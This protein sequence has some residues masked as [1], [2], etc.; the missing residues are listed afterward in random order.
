MSEAEASIPLHIFQELRALKALPRKG[1]RFIQQA[2]LRKSRLTLKQQGTPK[3]VRRH[4]S[5]ATIQN[6]T[7]GLPFPLFFN[8]I[9]L[10]ESSKSRFKTVL[11]SVGSK[12]FTR[13]LCP[14]N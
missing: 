8:A 13:H 9:A 1:F 10:N 3:M 5:Q 6:F 12:H 2:L 7:K 14:F 4:Q 11:V